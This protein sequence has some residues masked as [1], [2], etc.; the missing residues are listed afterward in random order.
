MWIL[1]K[2]RN[3]CHTVCVLVEWKR[4]LTSTSTTAQKVRSTHHPVI[5]SVASTV[6]FLRALNLE[7]HR[8]TR[9]SVMC[10]LLRGFLVLARATFLALCVPHVRPPLGTKRNFIT[11]RPL[12]L[13]PRHGTLTCVSAF[14]T[15]VPLASPTGLRSDSGHV[16]AVLRRNLSRHQTLTATHAS[17]SRAAPS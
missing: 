7:A 15:V 1:N 17:T 16:H 3:A 10:F 2:E 4:C 11:V 13:H 14:A 8:S 5:A 12:S 9:A 6:Q